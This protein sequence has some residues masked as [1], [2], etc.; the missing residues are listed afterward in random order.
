MIRQ[1]VYVSTARAGAG[2]AELHGIVD[3]ARAANGRNGLTGILAAG[4][5][6]YLQIVEGPADAVEALLTRLRADSRHENLRILQDIEVAAR[7]FPGRLMG[8]RVLAPEAPGLI[9]AQLRLRPMSAAEIVPALGNPAAAGLSQ[10]ALA[11]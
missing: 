3:K 7:N 5:G 9:A 1:V 10:V 8:L 11:A 6:V 2:D 4:N